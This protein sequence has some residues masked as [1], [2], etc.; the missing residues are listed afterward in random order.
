MSKV[1]SFDEFMSREEKINESR[2]DKGKSEIIN[3]A[4]GERL[5]DLYLKKGDKAKAK[6]KNIVIEIECKEDFNKV[7]SN[8]FYGD[9]SKYIKVISSSEKAD[10]FYLMT[11]ESFYENCWVEEL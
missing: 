8:L 3:E 2:V 10:D 9:I 5:Y 6:Y 1:L 11:F 4:K 7:N